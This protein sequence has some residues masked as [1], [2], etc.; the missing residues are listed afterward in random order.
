MATK[1]QIDLVGERP[2]GRRL[3]YDP[4]LPASLLHAS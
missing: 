2:T 1:R 3:M 4:A